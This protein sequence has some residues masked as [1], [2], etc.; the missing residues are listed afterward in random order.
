MKNVRFKKKKKK[1]ICECKMRS[2]NDPI[3][4]SSFFFLLEGYRK[5][6]KYNIKTLNLF[7]QQRREGGKLRKFGHWP[8]AILIFK[9]EK[10]IE[11][12]SQERFYFHV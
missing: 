7:D 3:F 12:D 10:G 4:C 8:G 1:L 2:S 6:K 11:F 9:L 5:R